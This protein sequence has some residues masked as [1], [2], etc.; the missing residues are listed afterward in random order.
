M[1]YP[2]LPECPMPKDDLA[3]IFHRSR[4]A[5]APSLAC[6]AHQTTEIRERSPEADFLLK[7]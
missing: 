4:E 2:G 3:S 6:G 5:A 7:K 1:G